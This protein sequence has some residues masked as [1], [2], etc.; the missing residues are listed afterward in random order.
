M[1]ETGLWC[2]PRHSWLS[3]LIS[4]FAKMLNTH[5]LPLS[6]AHL[7]NLSCQREKQTRKTRAWSTLTAEWVCG[8]DCT[9]SP[10]QKLLK[11]Q[12][13][14]ILAESTSLLLAKNYLYMGTLFFLLFP[15]CSL[16]WHCVF[17]Y[18]IMFPLRSHLILLHM[19]TQTRVAVLVHTG[20]IKTNIGTRFIC[21]G[22]FTQLCSAQCKLTAIYNIKRATAE[23]PEFYKTCKCKIPNN[24]YLPAI[25]RL[26]LG[27]VGRGIRWHQVAFGWNNLFPKEWIEPRFQTWWR[28]TMN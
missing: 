2:E 17:C 5:F 14:N 18:L 22:T 26:I 8:M 3:F 10:H 16:K 12:H 25:N 27:G 23:T 19:K 21:L 7:S 11:V 1:L 4:C 6:K 24:K 20:D 9:S 13:R 15:T 28:E